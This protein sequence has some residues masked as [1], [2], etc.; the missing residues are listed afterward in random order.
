MQLIRDKKEQM[1]E[2][3]KIAWPFPKKISGAGSFQIGFTNKVWYVP[4]R[5]Q[6]SDNKLQYEDFDTVS[7][8]RMLKEKKYVVVRLV[9]STDSNVDQLNFKWVISSLTHEGIELKIQFDKPE[10][11]SVYREKDFLEV[12]FLKTHEF[13]VDSQG[14]SNHILPAGFSLPIEIA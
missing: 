10:M 13:M 5:R 7:Y 12:I 8:R 4:I 2:P 11:I 9:P 3:E 6:L 14:L 1:F